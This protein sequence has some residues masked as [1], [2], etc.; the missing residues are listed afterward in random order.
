MRKKILGALAG[1]IIV[2]G[3][4]YSYTTAGT[5]V[6]TAE[7]IHGDI[8]LAVVDT[9]YVQASNQ[10]DIYATQSGRVAS[11]MVSVGQNVAKGQVIAVLDNKDLTMGS[12]QL[13]VQLSQA[14]AAVSAAEAALAQSKLDLVQAQANYDRSREL[15]GSGAIS[16]VEYDNAQALLDKVQAGIAAQEQSL[17]AAREQV[18]NYQS[19]LNSS[20][21][22][23]NELQIKSPIS[24]IVMQLPVRQ[25]DAVMY[26]TQLAKVAPPGALEIKV[27]IL[28]D[29]LGQIMVGNKAEI[30]APVLGGEVLNGEVAQIYPQAEEKQSALGVVQRRVPVIIKLDDIS[31]LK[32]GYETRVSIITGGKENI[33]LIPR[34]SVTTAPDGSKQVM[35]IIKNR[36]A[37]RKV[38]TGL[39]DTRSIEIT[40]GLEAGDLIVRDGSAS[41]KANARVKVKQE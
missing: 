13:Q 34:E 1:V 16:Q 12:A 18:A 9:G 32:P 30:T 20:R 29:D 21:Q 39:F 2:A 35:V 14:N 31:N 28:S 36:V 11:L 5:E 7:V 22:K 40:D 24:G 19:L 3:I 8:K 4:I 10:A 27:D 25:G 41:L 17:Q 6:D 23:E 15:F 33:L 37:I 26:G 38:S